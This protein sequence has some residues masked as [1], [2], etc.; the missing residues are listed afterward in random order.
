MR[1]LLIVP[2]ILLL[3]GCNKKEPESYF[4]ADKASVVF[5]KIEDICNQDSG[6]LWGT[7][8][9]GP[10]M[11]IDRATR[12]IT[13]NKNDVN[14]L[15]RVK[16]G[17]YTGIYPRENIVSTSAV[18]YG[19]TLFGLAPLPS[20]EDEYRIINRAIHSLFH[21]YQESIG[22]HPE[23]FN[24][25]IMDD[26]QARV[27]IKLE[28]KALRKAIEADGDEQL[29]ALRD[30]LIFRGS[31]R[32]MFPKH[33]AVQNRFENYEGLA[34]F[35]TYHLNTSSEE[36]FNSRL[37][38]YLDRVYQMQSFARSYGSV[39]GALYATLLSRK[40]FDFK[41]IRSDTIDLAKLVRQLYN[42]ELPPVC[43][44]VAGSIALNY[45][46]DEI[47]REEEKRILDIRE[48]L[49]SQVSVFTQKPVVYLELESPSF[50]FEPEDIQYLDTLGTL[51]HNIRVSDN[52]G[53]LTVDKIGCLISNN[54]KIMRITA[55]G[56]KIDKNHISGEGWQLIINEGWVLN[57]SQQDYYLKKLTP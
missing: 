33:A 41:T 6:K 14:G 46:I 52:W 49:S 30:A 35:T 40:G 5:K 2:L 22:I 54:Y 18:T 28:W 19:G 7:N 24:A 43:R 44:D 12:K 26:K 13:S 3:T 31:S 53:K 32:E 56:L 10:V 20:E 1:K 15:L 48:K 38:R 21:R 36:E 16:E 42:I 57:N 37:F 34:T 27:W 17:V 45:S 8:L 4:T 50:D 9:Y 11:F 51:Y 55:R 47:T 25:E 39:H 29:L 23:Y